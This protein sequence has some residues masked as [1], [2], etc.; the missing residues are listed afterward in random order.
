MS[1]KL[2]LIPRLIGITAAIFCIW[3]FLAIVTT[4]AGAFVMVKREPTLNFF[5]I[6]FTVHELR[7]L[8]NFGGLGASR[9]GRNLTGLAIARNIERHFE[10]IIVGWNDRGIMFFRPLGNR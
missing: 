7:S 1:N 4:S 2:S 3:F 9:L 6:D 8:S 5:Y 10:Y